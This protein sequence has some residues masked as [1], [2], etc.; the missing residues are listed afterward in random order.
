MSSHRHRPGP[1]GLSGAGRDAPP[2]AAPITQRVSVQLSLTIGEQSYPVAGG[3][4]TCI[5]LSLTRYG[6]S[7]RL[8]FWV[9]NNLD[10][11]G[12]EEDTLLAAFTTSDPIAVALS[13]APIRQDEEELLEDALPLSVKGLVSERAVYEQP[14]QGT[15]KPAVLARHYEVTFLDPA[16]LLWTQHDPCELYT[17][18]SIQEVLDLHKGD[19]IVL[20]YKG[21]FL[22]QKRPLIFIGPDLGGRGRDSFYDLVIWLCDHAALH[23]TYDYKDQSYRIADQP[24]DLPKATLLGRLDVQRLAV[25][26][27]PVPR[28]QARVHNAYSEDPR[29]QATTAPTG[30]SPLVRDRLLRTRLGAEFDDR[31]ALDGKRLYVRGP[32]LRMDFC[33]LPVRMF[34]PGDVVDLT[35]AAAWQAAGL[36][37]PAM[38]AADKLRAVELQLSLRSADGELREQE[39]GDIAEFHGFCTARLEQAAEQAPRLPDY[40]TPHYPHLVEGKVVSEQGEEDEET[41]DIETDS[42][43][44]IRRYKVKLPLF[45]DQLVRAPFLSA[46][47]TGH[48]YFPIYKNARV[49]CALTFSEVAVVDCLDFRVG[50]EVPLESQGNQLLMGKKLKSCV[51]MTMVYEQGAPVF[52][53]R[54]FHEGDVADSQTVRLQEGRLSVIVAETKD[55]AKSE[56]VRTIEV[57]LDKATGTTVTVEYPEKKTTQTLLMDGTQILLKVQGEKETST[58]TQVADTITIAAK[59]INVQAETIKV[60]STKTSDWHADQTLTMSSTKDFSISTE[61]NLMLKATKDAT[62]SAKNVTIT[63]D[64]GATLGGTDTTVKG[65]STLAASAPTLTLEGKTQG[66]LK[67]ATLE[68]SASAALTCKSSAAATFKGQLTSI[69]GSLIKVG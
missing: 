60:T 6:L 47:Q 9:L 52:T 35:A 41:Y 42:Q 15:D 31:A 37:V 12:V 25:S 2:A 40:V 4:V 19:K 16:A 38:A 30:L 7:G 46:P 21:E 23:F 27:P 63:A 5:E 67:G 20:A 59:N 64:Q 11:G 50:A 48:F 39:I 24:E 3:N 29:V 14:Y 32:L 43:T 57:T 51:A 28:Y 68:V 18:K 54:R 13:V 62:V 45:A 10:Y 44:S 8:G 55:N 33:Q 53:L 22:S 34:G 65:S 58:Y 17:D 1:S 56:K 36:A 61:A 69:E 66:T 26:Y 49:L